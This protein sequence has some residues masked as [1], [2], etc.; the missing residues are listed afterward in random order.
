VLKNNKLNLLISIVCAIVLWA[1]ITTVVNPATERTIN[2]ITVDLINTDALN[3]RGFTVSEGAPYR[4]DVTVTGARSEVAKLKESDFHATADV[5]GYKKGTWEV[6]VNVTTPNNIELVQV[7]SDI[8]SV[9][10]VDLVTVF[11]PVRL[12]YEDKFG[13]NQ[14]PGFINIVPEEMEVSGIAEAVDSIDYIRVLVPKGDLTDQLNTFRLPVTAINKSGQAVYNV[15]LS[16]SSVEVSGML[17]SIKQ[18]PLHI[19]TIGETN[20]NVEVTDMYIPTY[21]TI[22]GAAADIEGI[23]EINGPPIDL[24]TITTTMDIP[25][26]ELLLNHLP[27]GVEIADASQDLSVRIEVQGI[28]RKEFVYTADMIDVTNLAPSLSGHVNT[29]SVTVTV[30]APR[31][32]LANM[33]Q[34][35][36]KL[37]VDATEYRMAGSGIEMDVMA[38]CGLDIKEITIDP[39]K[40]RV[41]IIKE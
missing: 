27:T 13:W 22:R 41:T 5:T 12:E 18:V 11:K 21:V 35:D 40:V 2:N 3:D 26:E 38:D 4:V 9:N 33:T 31:D 1:Y 34:D 23:T 24:S 8:V 20:A 16:Q 7:R 14:E 17:C 28:A 25:I 19:E 30:F 6:P 36:I 15:R 39:T 37:Y 10:I 32:V 29:G